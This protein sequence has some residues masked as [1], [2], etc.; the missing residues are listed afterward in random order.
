MPHP[1]VNVC[2]TCW[3]WWH[4]C[5]LPP[6]WPGRPP[7]R[8]RSRPSPRPSPQS[9]AARVQFSSLY[10][11]SSMV[12]HR[13]EAAALRVRISKYCQWRSTG[14]NKNKIK[15]AWAENKPTLGTIITY[16]YI[17][18]CSTKSL[19]LCGKLVRKEQL[20]IWLAWSSGNTTSM[21]MLI[22]KTVSQQVIRF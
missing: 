7:P 2:G 18:Y 19:H 1:N 22:F 17:V 21:A 15:M 10:C 6:P 13:E 9:C 16:Y 11:S 14:I 12:T 8:S 20:K 5:P 3:M 4:A